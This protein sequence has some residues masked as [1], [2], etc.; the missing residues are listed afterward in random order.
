MN[1]LYVAYV[2]T[3]VIHVIYLGSLVTRYL[4]LRQDLDELKRK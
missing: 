2:A 4:R 3:W 1:F